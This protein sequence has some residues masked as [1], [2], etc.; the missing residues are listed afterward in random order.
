MMKQVPTDKG[1]HFI[2]LS[3]KGDVIVLLLA[4]TVDFHAVAEN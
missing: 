3:F 4:P 1:F 2:R